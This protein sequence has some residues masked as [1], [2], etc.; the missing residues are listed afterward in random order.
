MTP[1]QYRNALAALD[2][3]Q[4]EAAE[5]LDYS[6]RT[7]NAYASGEMTVPLP[8]AVLL[9]LLVAGKIRLEDVRG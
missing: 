3:T 8:I 5:L 2:L 6:L 7:S 9:R 4:G 1:T